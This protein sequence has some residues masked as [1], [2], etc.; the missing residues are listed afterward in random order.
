[1]TTVRTASHP[2]II[3]TQPTMSLLPSLNDGR[4]RWPMQCGFRTARRQGY[5]AFPS[6]HE[7]QRLWQRSPTIGRRCTVVCHDRFEMNDVTQGL[8]W[9]LC[10]HTLLA[11]LGRANERVAQSEGFES[12]HL[13]QHHF[14]IWSTLLHSRKNRSKRWDRKTVCADH[15]SGRRIRRP[16]NQ[17]SDT[18]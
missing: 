11:A 12:P 2:K 15:E 7:R 1:M 5:G 17:P 16:T 4:A 3:R 18:A 6:G 8:G 14:E 10:G 9:A 13:R